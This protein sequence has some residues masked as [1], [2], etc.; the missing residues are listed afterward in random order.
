MV[1][2]PPFPGLTP[3]SL[4]YPFAASALFVQC[5]YFSA[6]T[7]QFFCF[8]VFAFFYNTLLLV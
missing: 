4:V 7:T 5:K 8:C 1:E 2:F 6:N 3:V